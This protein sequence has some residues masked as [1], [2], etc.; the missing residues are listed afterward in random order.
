VT[1]DFMTAKLV[2]LSVITSPIA[3]TGVSTIHFWLFITNVWSLE[4]PVPSFHVMISMMILLIIRYSH[5]DL[6]FQRKRF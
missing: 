3:G 5:G 6:H 4:W 2:G 1:A